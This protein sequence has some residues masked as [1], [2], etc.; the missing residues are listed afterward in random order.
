MSD[1]QVIDLNVFF[2][3]QKGFM[4]IFLNENYKPSDNPVVNQMKND[5]IKNKY[6][7]F[8][9]HDEINKKI[10]FA[11]FTPFHKFYYKNNIVNFGEYNQFLHNL[12]NSIKEENINFPDIYISNSTF[13]R[14]FLDQNNP[15]MEVDKDCF[16]NIEKFKF[17][18]G[19]EIAHLILHKNEE[20][21]LSQ[22]NFDTLKLVS[23]KIWLIIGFYLI[24]SIYSVFLITS[25][26]LLDPKNVPN[27][28]SL[29]LIILT[30]SIPFTYFFMSFKTFKKRSLN[31]F[32]EFY[33]D[34][35]SI[36]LVGPVKTESLDF[37]SFENGYTHPSGTDRNYF[38][39]K[40]KKYFIE[41]NKLP[42]F[43]PPNFRKSVKYFFLSFSE[44]IYLLRKNK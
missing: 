32:R 20:K 44:I 3:D 8:A 24:A 36:K 15:T 29:L 16:E 18:V 1:N 28:I 21:I 22:Y 4:M 5:M 10:T 17:T 42:E 26:I 34:Y 43:N 27:Y 37:K 23:K 9:H 31:Y 40:N 11:N 12:K 14:I 35:L 6:W 19:H 30:Y 39:E 7:L 41:N 38:Y 33:S 2:E 13:G 25:E